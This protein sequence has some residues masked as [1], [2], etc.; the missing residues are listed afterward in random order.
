MPKSLTSGTPKLVEIRSLKIIGRN[1]AYN[2]STRYSLYGYPKLNK[3]E[4]A[5]LND[6][7]EIELRNNDNF[8]D[9]YTKWLYAMNGKTRV[10]AIYGIGWGMMQHRCMQLGEEK[11]I[12]IIKNY[13][14]I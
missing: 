14:N 4:W 1:E 8:I 5:L 6:R 7:L 13:W 10:F 12:I 2:G 11:Q 3:L 9:D